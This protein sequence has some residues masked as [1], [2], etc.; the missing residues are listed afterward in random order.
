M[1][2]GVSASRSYQL[3]VTLKD[4]DPPIWRRVVVPE[5]MTL[6]KLHLVLQI[7]MGW[8]NYHMHAF[9]VGKQQFGERG[10]LDGAKDEAKVRL[11]EVFAKVGGKIAYEYDFGDG[12]EHEIA[13]ESIL[14]DAS[15]PTAAVCL[16][17]QRACPPEDCGGIYGYADIL[18]AISDKK[19]PEY[20]QLREWLGGPFDPERFD[21][22]AVNS[23]LKQLR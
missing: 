7:S 16:E 22:R 20:K 15:Q 21:V 6:A 4:S 13:L 18:E 11:N 12:W 17:G 5:D 1:P 2:A 9:T 23:R 3:K 19:H 8:E 14:S 10:M